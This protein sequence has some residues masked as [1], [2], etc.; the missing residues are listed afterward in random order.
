MSPSRSSWR[1]ATLQF[2]GVAVPVE[3]LAREHCRAWLREHLHGLDPERD[4]TIH[5]LIRPT[6]PD[7]TDLYLRQQRTGIRLANDTSFGVGYAPPSALE[8]IVERVE[9]ELNAAR[10]KQAH[11]ELGEDIK[12]MGLRD[13]E[14]VRLT[15][16]CAFI[17]RFVAG[18]DDYL[19]KRD[20]L[21][22]L[23][24]EVAREAAGGDVA[25]AVNAADDPETGSVYLTV[26]GTSAEAGD[27]GQ[28]GRGNRASGL[29]TP[30]RPMS[31][32]AV[33]GKNPVTHVGRL[34][35]LVAPRIAEALV[36]QLAPVAAAECCLV[37]QI[38][39][40][41]GVPRS[42]TCASRPWATPRWTRSRRRSRRSSAG[43][44]HR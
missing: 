3:E 37:S 6:S 32:E 34:Y 22:E 42:R 24:R 29:I 13:R 27:D 36:G 19:R 40:P 2:R 4:V 43:S 38:G 10:V 5:C 16:A 23:A 31:L 25:V 18:L 26:T 44:W 21:A 39:R 12:V 17:D 1:A 20:R 35:S 9:R 30:G 7:L 33:A 28:V 14:Q 15:L 11:P 8:R 41:V